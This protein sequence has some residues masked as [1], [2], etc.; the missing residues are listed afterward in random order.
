MSSTYKLL[1][2]PNEIR[3]ILF[4]LSLILVLAPYA[5]GKDFGIFK[6]PK[7][8]E[9]VNKRLKYVGPLCVVLVIVGFLP[10]WHP[11]KLTLTFQLTNNTGKEV[12]VLPW[13]DIYVFESDPGSGVNVS[14]PSYSR[15]LKPVHTPSNTP[16]I[17]P[18]GN[19]RVFQTTL[20]IEGSLKYLYER[21]AGTLQVSFF[22]CD[23]KYLQSGAWTLSSRLR[24]ISSLE[25]DL[26]KS[27]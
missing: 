17:I 4:L 20:P 13:C 5:A 25:V 14:Y 19:T 16:F 6:I 12:S 22:D 23:K 11:M 9:K 10:L 2:L 26:H 3:I 1:L 24:N 27:R 7:F 15:E 8:S 21:N 18:V